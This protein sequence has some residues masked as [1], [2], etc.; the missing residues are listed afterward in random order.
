MLAANGV[1]DRCSRRTTNTRRR[2]RSRTRSSPTTA[3]AR[4]GSPTASSSRRRTTRPTTAASSTTRPTA[5]RPTPTSPRWI[6]DAANGLLEKAL[7]GVQAHAAR[8]GA[9]ARRRRTGTTTSAAT[10]PTSATSSTS[11]RSAAPRCAW[12]SIRSAAPACTTGR[13]SPSAT[14]I[15]LTVVSD[16]V[17]PTFRFMTLDWDGKIRMDPS[18]PYAMQRL[19]D[20]KDRFDIAFACDTDHD[21]HGIVTASAGLLP[22]NHYLAV[23]IDYLFRNRPQ[24]PAHAGGRQD[25]G[26]HAADRP[27]RGA[28]RPRALRSAGRLQVVRRRPARRLARLRRRGERG[29]RRSC[30]ATAASGPPTRTA[31]CRRCSSAEITARTGRDPGALYDALDARARRAV[32]PTASRRRPRPQQK[33]QLAALSPEAAR[34]QRARRRADRAA[35][36][37]RRR[38]TARRSAASR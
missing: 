23:V 14:G 36:S 6:E 4:A 33:K 10:S 16:V 24:W 30:A 1:D 13:A 17:D 37:T 19:I 20:L 5:A 21:R 38:A 29:R 35:C 9:A 22:P 3:A 31:S 32:Q 12:A 25:G 27:R 2:R 8:A 15:D 7:A 11:T 18:S 28:P 26:Q 34:R